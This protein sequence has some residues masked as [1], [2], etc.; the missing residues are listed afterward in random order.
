VRVVPSVG[1]GGNT[2]AKLD[3]LAGDVVAWPCPNVLAVEVDPE[4]APQ[5]LLELDGQLY[6]PRPRLP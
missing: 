3:A 4:G 1:A 6:S 5:L 2:G